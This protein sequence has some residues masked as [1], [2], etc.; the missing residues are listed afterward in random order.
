MLLGFIDMQNITAPVGVDPN[1]H[2]KTLLAQV[3]TD[4]QSIIWTPYDV[5]LGY[6]VWKACCMPSH[7]LEEFLA[8]DVMDNI[9]TEFV[10][11]GDLVEMGPVGQN[12][13]G[14]VQGAVAEYD[15]ELVSVKQHRRIHKRHAMPYAATVL[16]EVRTRFGVPS[17]TAA[18]ELAVRRHAKDIMTKHGLRPTHMARLLPY[19]CRVAFIPTDD[20]IHAATWGNSEAAKARERV[21]NS[22]APRHL[23]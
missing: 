2:V 17:R 23:E 7:E 13:G 9:A 6:K 20:D 12:P 15:M 21:F 14:S 4:T 22:L 19:I 5:W 18:N 11:N 10:G 8:L 3:H 1:D 16:A